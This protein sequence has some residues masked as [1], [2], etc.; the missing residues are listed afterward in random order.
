V[1]DAP[2]VGH[3]GI[4]LT[5]IGAGWVSTELA[6]RPEMLQQDGVVHAG[7]ISTLADHTAGA[8]AGSTLGPGRT[9]LT[10]ELKINLLRPATGERL[11]C[12]ARVVRAGR[13]LVVAE[14]EVFAADQLAA[15]ALVT[16]APVSAS[17]LG[18]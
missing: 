6:I 8:A 14:S 18:R 13:R 16:L 3:L 10:V 4:E 9:P 12:R 5:G 15:K 7:V 11:R 2:F 1:S 17:H